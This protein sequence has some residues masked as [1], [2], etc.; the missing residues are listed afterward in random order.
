MF[1]LVHFKLILFD[2]DLEIVFGDKFMV[3]VAHEKGT[4]WAE[5]N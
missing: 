5:S 2:I 4:H 3:F 1:G